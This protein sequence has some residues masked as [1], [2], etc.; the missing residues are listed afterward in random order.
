MLHDDTMRLLLGLRLVSVN[1]TCE[2][3][4]FRSYGTTHLTLLS[5][6][7][8]EHSFQTFLSGISGLVSTTDGGSRSDDNAAT[9][10]GRRR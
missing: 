9:K 8:I 2:R 10:H 3:T 7:S 4:L 1:A 5:A 6:C